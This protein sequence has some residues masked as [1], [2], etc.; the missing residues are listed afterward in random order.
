MEFSVSGKSLQVVKDNYIGLA[1]L[2]IEIGEQSDH[3]RAAHEIAA[4][5]YVIGEHSLNVIAFVFRIGATTLLLA[6]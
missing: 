5:T 3:A 6:L 1:L 4:P 2:R